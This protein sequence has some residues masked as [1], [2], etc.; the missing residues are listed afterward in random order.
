MWQRYCTLVVNCNS[1]GKKMN[2]TLM[3]P[4]D[5]GRWY[6]ADDEGNSFPLVERHEDHPK[7]SALLGWNAP[8]GVT[9]QEEIIDSALDWLMSHTGEDFTAPPHVAE[10]FRQLNEDNES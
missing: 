2:V 10:F 4:D 3:G 9:D 1:G 6:L 7:G 8:E 5:L